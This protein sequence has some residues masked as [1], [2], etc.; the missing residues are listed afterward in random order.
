VLLLS[1]GTLIIHS[2]YAVPS[3]QWAGLRGVWHLDVV[4]RM[5]LEEREAEAPGQGRAVLSTTGR[6]HDWQAFGWARRSHGG[7][8]LGWMAVDYP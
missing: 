4:L 3:H 6:C 5:R 2:M 7:M 8:T 1:L